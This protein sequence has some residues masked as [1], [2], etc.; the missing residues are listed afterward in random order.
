MLKDNKLNLTGFNKTKLN[1]S[2]VDCWNFPTGAAFKR[3]DQFVS[4]HMV[5]CKMYAKVNMLKSLNYWYI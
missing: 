2:F 4:D 5:K 1:H 3:H